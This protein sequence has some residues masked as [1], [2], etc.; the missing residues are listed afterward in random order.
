MRYEVLV[1]FIHSEIM[2][3][4]KT[5]MGVTKGSSIPTSL[6][7]MTVVLSV[8]VFSSVTERN[9][10]GDLYGLFNYSLILM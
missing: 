5:P 3:N 2:G 1:L 6:P 4:C 9:E 8:S 10:L 7:R